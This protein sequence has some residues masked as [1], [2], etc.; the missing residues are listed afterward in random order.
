MSRLTPCAR[1]RLKRHVISSACKSVSF[2]YFFLAAKLRK[3][4]KENETSVQNETKN[5]KGPPTTVLQDSSLANPTYLLFSSTIVGGSLQFLVSFCSYWAVGFYRSDRLRLFLAWFCSCALP[6]RIDMANVHVIL[7]DA[8]VTVWASCSLMTWC[9]SACFE[10]YETWSSKGTGH[11][12][13][14]LRW[15]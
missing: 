9:G 3:G 6:C 5:C 2:C 15:H 13:L 4:I 12:A 10:W 8:S 11:L 1:N 14:Y 7:Q